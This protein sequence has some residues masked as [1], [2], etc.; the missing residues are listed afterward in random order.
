MIDKEKKSD[1]II[2]G[3]A[4]PRDYRKVPGRANGYA[5][6]PGSGPDGEFCKT[7]AHSFPHRMGSKWY[8]CELMRANW[9]HGRG[10][11]ILVN[12]KACLR[13]EKGWVRP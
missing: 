5:A 9:T 4:N 2:F 3:Q 6:P 10:T 12:A 1:P 7:C 8:K 13:W 11:D